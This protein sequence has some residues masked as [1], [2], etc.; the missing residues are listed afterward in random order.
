MGE[1]SLALALGGILLALAFLVNIV[2][3][4][5][6]HRPPWWLGR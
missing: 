6:Q 1:Y 5:L 4:R 2:F 3:I